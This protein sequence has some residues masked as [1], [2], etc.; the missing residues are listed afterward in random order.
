LLILSVM[1]RAL[2]RPTPPDGVWRDG[3]PAGRR[4]QS[5]RKDPTRCGRTKSPPQAASGCSRAGLLFTCPG[6]RRGEQSLRA[7]GT[8]ADNPGNKKTAG[9]IDR[10]VYPTGSLSC[11]ISGLTVGKRAFNNCKGLLMA[12]FQPDLTFCMPHMRLCLSAVGN[13]VMPSKGA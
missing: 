4:R 12:L 11:N 10:S 8:H 9:K 2:L 7:R 6:Y 13:Q 5:G 1:I 3:E